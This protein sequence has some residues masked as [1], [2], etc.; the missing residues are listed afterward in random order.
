MCLAAF[1]PGASD[2]SGQE[3]ASTTDRVRGPPWGV[4]TPTP[5]ASM[6]ATVLSPQASRIADA[7]QQRTLERGTA[8]LLG[9]LSDVHWALPLAVMHSRSNTGVGVSTAAST[10]Q[11]H[12]R[13][14]QPAH[15][16]VL[17][18]VERGEDNGLDLATWIRSKLGT[19][20]PPIIIISKR[21][22]D[23]PR[24]AGIAGGAD[25]FFGKD[26]C[27]SGRSLGAQAQLLKARQ[28]AA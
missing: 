15:E 10:F 28:R 1:C 26:E 14:R 8:C 18:H 7:A 21:A 23:A 22:S 9:D 11:T 19:T 20:A 3:A 17:L 2:D 13:R 16:V 12:E 27:G 24:R 25:R 6:T 5:C 4:R